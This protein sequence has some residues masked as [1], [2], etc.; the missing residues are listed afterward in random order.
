M[1]AVYRV[2]RAAQLGALCW[3]LTA[4]GALPNGH[5][6]VRHPL[7]NKVWDVSAQRPVDP[8][9]VVARAV[10]ARFV[11]LGEIHDDR[12]HH[13]LQ[14]LILQQLVKGGRRPALVMEQ[15]DTDQQVAMD[16]ILSDGKPLEVQLLALS[17]LMRKSWDWPVY[18]PIVRTAVQNGLPLLAANLSRESL[19]QVGRDGYA[20][21]GPGEESRL[22]LQPV[23]SAD[24]Q[25]QMVRDISGGHCG[26]LSEHM[27]EIIS[28]SQRARDAVIADVML[29]HQDVGAV[30]I[31]GRN[32]ARGDMAVP[33]YLANRAPQLSVLTLAFAEVAAPTDPRAYSHGPLGQMFDYVWFTP[34]V[35]RQTNPCADMPKLASP[36]AP[37]SAAK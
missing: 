5:P 26:K 22:A 34:P 6:A 37:A 1:R 27:G 13:R 32:H 33:I 36:V 2:L 30:A 31:L 18:E 8:D 29:K 19:R 12:E 10:A 25:A 24:R 17:G 23:W 4:C 35:M 20:A 9:T 3:L 15:F 11:L 14:A 16:A 21:L 7:F 28:K